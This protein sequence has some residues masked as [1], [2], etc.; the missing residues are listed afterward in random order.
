MR[1]HRF[2]VAAAALLVFGIGAGH[3]VR[4]QEGVPRFPIE[5]FSV[6]G[7][8]L[9]PQA[10][11]D[12]AVRPF[13]GPERDFGDVQ[14][15]LDALED[16]YRL[17][18][19]NT[20]T[21][22]LPEQ[23]LEKGEVRFQVIEG[24]VNEIRISGQT[25]FDEDNVRAAL[26]TLRPGEPPRIDDVS[27]NLRIAN[28]NPARKIALQMQPGENDGEIDALVKITDERPW[29]IGATL[30]NTGT[31]QTGKRRLGLMFQH[32]NLWN[33]DHVLTWQYQTSPDG[34]ENVRVHALAYR[35]PL[36]ALGDALDF[37]ATHS[38][39]NAGTIAAGPVNLAISG[40]GLVFG[41]RYTMN[42]RRRGNY[43]QQLVFGIDHKAFRNGI[44]AAGINLGNDIT[45]HPLSL[46]YNGRWQD[47]GGSEVS[48][49][50][51][52]ARN[53]P[54]GK[55]GRQEDFD[56]ARFGAPKDFSVVRG[57]FTASH[58]FRSDW[59]LRLT[60]SGQ[61]TND[62]LVPGEQF[63]IG[64]AAS[65]RG[66]QEREVANDRGYMV[67]F[68]TYT[69]ELCGALGGTHRCRA[70]AFVEGGSVSRVDPLPGEKRRENISSA[71]VGM[72]YTWSKNMT[73]QTDY[74]HVLDGGGTQARG[75]WRL[76]GRLGI[77]F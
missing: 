28:E 48:L 58:A 11:I 77:F 4:A 75:D 34:W 19:Y 7:N 14:R 16:R 30:D 64:G 61:W 20:V 40:S 56:L 68:E 63:G 46:Q 76:H 54:G 42:L 41:S 18:G 17:R 55:H 57:G 23:V 66:F 70:L 32:A 44:D 51:S 65:V 69:P 36:Y 3:S 52:L 45:V 8:T 31:G 10:E 27:A 73:F 35:L 26:P 53:I 29:K 60:G 38:N 33:R 49:F 47:A 2:F 21:V 43:E 71:G 72:R 67:S 5:R 50:G 24:R 6:T 15:A 1:Q 9:L 22:L 25:H 13:V 74:G 62:P 59:Q 39:V 37:Y 12:A